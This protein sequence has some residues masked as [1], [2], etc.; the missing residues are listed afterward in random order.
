MRGRNIIWTQ[1]A[2]AQ[3]RAIDQETALH[4]LH[5]LARMT[6]SGDGD[7][8]HL[9]DSDPP[10]YRLRVGDYRVLFHS[11]EAG[12]QIVAVKHRREAYR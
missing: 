9:R 12:I 1:H 4:I 5:A 3:L 6:A 11:I 2:K 10:Q 7:V 8:K